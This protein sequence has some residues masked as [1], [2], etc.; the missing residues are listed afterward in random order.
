MFT[1]YNKN[2]RMF[3]V[4]LININSYTST[5]ISRALNTRRSLMNLHDVLCLTVLIV[6]IIFLFFLRYYS[7]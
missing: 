5:S 4:K 7:N 3:E 2:E 1:E 6:F